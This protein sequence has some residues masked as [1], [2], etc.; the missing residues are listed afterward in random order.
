MAA[1][2]MFQKYKKYKNNRY[3]IYENKSENSK[4]KLIKKFINQKR[5]RYSENPRI[6]W[7]ND[8]RT[9]ARDKKHYNKISSAEYELLDIK[10]VKLAYQLQ[11]KRNIKKLISKEQLLNTVVSEK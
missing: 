6:Q 11:N 9:R 1:G 10:T 8:I 5:F 7:E 3:E 4:K 2:K